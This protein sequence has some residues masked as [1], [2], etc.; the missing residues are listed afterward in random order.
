[1]GVALDWYRREICQR[2][3][4]THGDAGELDCILHRLADLRLQQ[5]N[6]T[7]GPP[8]ESNLKP[9]SAPAES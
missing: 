5:R 7:M 6:A 8:M 1:M 9:R 2:E 4:H 3:S